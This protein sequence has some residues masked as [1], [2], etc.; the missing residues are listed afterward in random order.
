MQRL[1]K[2]EAE[3]IET[4]PVVF[5]MGARG[6]VLEREHA[7]YVQKQNGAFLR[8]VLKIHKTGEGREQKAQSHECPH[9]KRTRE[10]SCQSER[11]ERHDGK[12]KS[13]T[14]LQ[15]RR[16]RTGTR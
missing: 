14:P 5:R 6:G 11:K 8:A 15:R 16:S 1:E 13:T 10:R 7:G 3:M 12:Q 2:E 9:E 4:F